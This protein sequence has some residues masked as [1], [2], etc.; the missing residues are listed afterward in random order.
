MYYDDISL[1]CKSYIGGD[2]IGEIPVYS[3]IIEG[4]VLWSC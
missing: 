2:K 1:G 4:R 3:D